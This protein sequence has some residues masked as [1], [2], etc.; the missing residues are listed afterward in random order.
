[1]L[2]LAGVNA[3]AIA[4]P[5]LLEAVVRNKSLMFADNSASYETAL[6]GGLRLMPSER[7]MDRL[8]AG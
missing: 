3:K 7:I 6:P 1:M 8:Q 2:D 5:D 4:Q